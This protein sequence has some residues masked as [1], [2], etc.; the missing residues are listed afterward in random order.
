MHGVSSLFPVVLTNRPLFFSFRGRDEE[1]IRNWRSFRDAGASAVS[2]PIGG[3]KREPSEHL[4]IREI[5]QD[6]D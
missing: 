6:D 1:W 2:V 3:G 4:G 5:I